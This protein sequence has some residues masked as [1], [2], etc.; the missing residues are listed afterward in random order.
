MAKKKKQ[1][2]KR[3]STQQ[4]QATGSTLLPVSAASSFGIKCNV[5]L[6]LSK[7]AS[8]SKQLSAS[9]IHQQL[10]EIK[11][12][13]DLAASIFRISKGSLPIQKIAKPLANLIHLCEHFATSDICR[14][15]VLKEYKEVFPGKTLREVIIQYAQNMLTFFALACT[16]QNGH[17]LLIETFI[18]Y[19]QRLALICEDS[20]FVILAAGIDAELANSYG[21]IGDYPR[22]LETFERMEPSNIKDFLRAGRMGDLCLF[23]I[24]ELDNWL[25]D[26]ID[27]IPAADHAAI[28]TALGPPQPKELTPAV[29]DLVKQLSAMST[30]HDPSIDFDIMSQLSTIGTGLEPGQQEKTLAVKQQ[31][32]S[33]EIIALVEKYGELALAAL[34]ETDEE[35][36]YLP[37]IIAYSIFRA[38]ASDRNVSTGKM[39]EKFYQALKMFPSEKTMM[40]IDID[41]S[42]QMKGKLYFQKAVMIHLY[43]NFLQYRLPQEERLIYSLDKNFRETL[44]LAAELQFFPAE[45]LACEFVESD[46]RMRAYQ[47]K[48][49]EGGS[50]SA[51]YNEAYDLITDGGLQNQADVK[52]IFDYLEKSSKQGYAKATFTLAQ[53]YFGKFQPSVVEINHEKALEYYK[54]AAEQG[55]ISALLEIGRIHLFFSE[56]P[57]FF[58]ALGLWQQVKQESPDTVEVYTLLATSYLHRILSLH[59]LRNQSKITP[60]IMAKWPRIII[61][62]VIQG[63]LQC[64]TGLEK[65]ATAAKKINLT[66]TEQADLAIKQMEFFTLICSLITHV[67]S[68]VQQGHS[69]FLEKLLNELFRQLDFMSLSQ[70]LP[71]AR[72]FQEVIMMENDSVTAD[73]EHTPTTAIGNFFE[74]LQND[75]AYSS[76]DTLIT[77]KYEERSL[78]FEAQKEDIKTAW[79]TFDDF[80][81][82]DEK[83]FSVAE[84]FSRGHATISFVFQVYNDF[85]DQELSNIILT[86]YETSCLIWQT[87][88]NHRDIF[89]S[90]RG[91]FNNLLKSLMRELERLS[92]SEEECIENMLSY[93]P[94]ALIALGRLRLSRDEKILHN[95]LGVLIQLIMKYS[96]RFA[97]E[98]DIALLYAFTLLPIADINQ[99]GNQFLFV[100]LQKL[101]S[102]ELSEEAL[103]FSQLSQLYY[104]LVVIDAKQRTKIDFPLD[105]YQQ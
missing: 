1:N 84:D 94:K 40:L 7:A 4:M 49:A 102:S 88:S 48:A 39:Q 77:R 70:C 68:S 61:S 44:I 47:Q 15:R 50:V 99:A 66:P 37:F 36:L 85:G 72:E 92:D 74:N 22:M 98:D 21:A 30:D 12:V 103:T 16:Q 73:I 17:N 58:Y 97:L 41:N 63:L 32:K 96:Q 78:F 67:N 81:M 62:Y 42:D 65:L 76:L 82:I 52:K 19:R 89:A 80:L 27:S 100:V 69:I 3:D 24:S 31:Y 25:V 75:S 53:I 28:A 57:D 29:L 34:S 55:K 93:L 14:E 6:P 59:N 46:P 10:K 43:H 87:G 54:M 104:S 18:D 79:L 5:Q 90:Y 56:K 35:A 33:H 8:T 71:L 83:L 26:S 38:I 23:L 60:D 9:Q 13:G 51:L 95:I 101:Q 91:Q 11:R 45:M 64:K 86:L 20:L 105:L 2:L